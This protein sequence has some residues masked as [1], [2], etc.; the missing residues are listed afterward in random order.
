MLPK[1]LSNKYLTIVLILAF[2]IAKA[3]SGCKEIKATIEVFQ[4]GQKSEKASVTIDFHGQPTISFIVSI[5]GPKTFFK[6][7]IKETE[8]NELQKGT[9]TLVF[10]GRHEE[11][12]YCM[13]H[14]EFTI[15]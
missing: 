2:G 8:L 3:Q 4:V 13:K 7:D 12:N 9:Y 1:S 11:D 14:L 10:A 6:K 15:N 5:I